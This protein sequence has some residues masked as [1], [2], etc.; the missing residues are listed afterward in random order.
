MIIPRGLKIEVNPEG[1]LSI[2]APGNL[3]VQNSGKYGTLE[4]LK[5]SI[6][7]D[8]GVEVVGGI[9]HYARTMSEGA[10]SVRAL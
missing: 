7:I 2:H 3:V 1:E 5:G 9:P 8:R 6:R 4:S 10:A